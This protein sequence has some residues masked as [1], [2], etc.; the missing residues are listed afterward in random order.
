MEGINETQDVI[1]FISELAG[2]IEAAKADGIVDI[3]DV[4]KGLA[5]LPSAAAAVKGYDK[6]DDEFKD[7]NG[8]ERDILLADFKTAAFKLVAALT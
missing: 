8:E 7:L 6:I 3:W 2:A 5:V 4:A 1:K